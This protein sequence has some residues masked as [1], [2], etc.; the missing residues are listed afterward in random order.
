MRHPARWAALGVGVLVCVLGVVLATQVGTSPTQDAQ[1]SR[2]LG[3]AAPRFTAHTFDGGTISTQTLAG[4][5]VIV[6]FWNSWCIP[7]QQEL[8]VLRQFAERHAGD[9]SFT[10]LG[11]LRDDTTAAAR[12]Y[13]AAEG[14]TWPLAADPGSSLALAFGTRGQPETYAIS[15]RGTI[16]ASQFGPVS[17]GNLETML[18]AARGAS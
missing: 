18:A 5:P 13:A 1:S 10:L 16:V 14:M 11:V 7:C 8:P 12:H 4:Q 2:L 6:N 17:L 9:S 15:A 3:K